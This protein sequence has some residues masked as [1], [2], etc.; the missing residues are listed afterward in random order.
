MEVYVDL[1]AGR[2]IG[3]GSRLVSGERY[4]NCSEFE[5]FKFPSCICLL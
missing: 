5:L 1:V 4:V 3:A 2:D